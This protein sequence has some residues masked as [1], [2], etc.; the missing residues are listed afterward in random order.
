MICKKNLISLK[1]LDENDCKQIV[2]KDILKVSKE[3]LVVIKVQKFKNLNYSIRNYFIGGATIT[4]TTI[5]K[6]RC[7]K[8]IFVI[9][10]AIESYEQTQII[11]NKDT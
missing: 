8:L 4:I 6:Q 3:T 1:A 10:Y 5:I 2:E 11:R 7:Y 9:A